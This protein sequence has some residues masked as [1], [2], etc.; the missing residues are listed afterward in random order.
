MSCWSCLFPGTLAA[1]LIEL[2]YGLVMFLRL[3]V[4]H[5]VC[6]P[7][8]LVFLC[9]RDSVFLSNEPKVLFLGSLVSY[10]II[11]ASK[12]FIS[13]ISRAKFL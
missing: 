10:Q 5:V 12:Q 7:V 6:G 3:A 13:P 8:R 9:L 2:L 1:V 4:H 11:S